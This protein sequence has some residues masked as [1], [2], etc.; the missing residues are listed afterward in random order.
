[1]EEVR[2]LPQLCASETSQQTSKCRLAWH[3]Q[4]P[5]SPCHTSQQPQL[6]LWKTQVLAWVIMVGFL[7]CTVST[8]MEMA[9][10]QG[11]CAARL[12]P[13]LPLL[14]WLSPSCLHFW[15]IVYWQGKILRLGKTVQN[16]LGYIPIPPRTG[17][18]LTLQPGNP[19]L[20][21]GVKAQSRVLSGSF[22]CSAKWDMCWWEFIYSGQLSWTLGDCFA[23]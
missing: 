19:S 11:S 12:M 21:C 9:W 8:G 22:S 23:S 7:Q 16:S 14:A 13:R 15:A 3:A 18:H 10:E 5:V 6:W 4:F 20:P 17:C 2:T 1:M